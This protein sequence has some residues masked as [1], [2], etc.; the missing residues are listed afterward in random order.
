[1][2]EPEAALFKTKAT[3]QTI[4][5][6]L[7]MCRITN[8]FNTPIMTILSCSIISVQSAATWL[9]VCPVYLFSVLDFRFLRAMT[10]SFCQWDK[11]IKNFIRVTS[12]LKT[13]H[14]YPSFSDERRPHPFPWLPHGL[15]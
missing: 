12:L 6:I 11:K 14:L 15:Q 13:F 9:R 10:M 2:K 8:F 5:L 7:L 1:M 3:I 4:T